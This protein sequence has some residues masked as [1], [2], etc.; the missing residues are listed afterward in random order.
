[1]KKHF[2]P[3]WISSTQVRKQRKYR[4]NAPLHIKHRFLSAHLSKV[5]RQK[6]GKRSLPIRQGDEVLVMRG[7][8]AGKK[9]KVSS[10]NLSKTQ[11]ILEGLQRTKRDGTKIPVYFHP[12]VL[13]INTIALEDK[14]RSAAI[15]RKQSI[16]PK[17][18]K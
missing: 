13:Q 8:F 2:S 12:R 14:E 4:H 11:V 5:L 6:H 3:S 10:V 15:N 16:S 17:G 9:A 1:M 18:A 7:S